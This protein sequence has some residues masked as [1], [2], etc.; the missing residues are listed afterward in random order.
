MLTELKELT[1]QKSPYQNKLWTIFGHSRGHAG[2]AG[3]GGSFIY[4]SSARIFNTMILNNI[5]DFE[6]IIFIVDSI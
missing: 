6:M 2:Q 4:V 3:M 1:E 5:I